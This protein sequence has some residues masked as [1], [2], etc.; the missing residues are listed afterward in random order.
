MNS[1]LKYQLCLLLLLSCFINGRSAPLLTNFTWNS[2]CL[3]DSISFRIT[4]DIDQIDSVK[5][6][7]GDPASLALDSSKRE[8]N[9]GHRYRATGPYTVTLIAFRGGV[10]DTTT[11]V[12]TIV[13]K[14]LVTMDP[15]ITLCENAPLYTITVTVDPST[16][17]TGMEVITWQDTVT[18]FGLTYDVTET[19]TYRI[20]FD[21]CQ[22]DDSVNVF[23]SPVP[24]FELG[25]DLNL[26]TDERITLDATAQ[27]ADY[28]WSTGE[29]SP[30]ILVDGN[31]SGQY[32]VEA[33]I[34]GCGVYRDT[35]NVNFSGMPQTFD[36]GKDTLLCAGE[37]ITIR[38]DV[39]AAI[40]Y[41][42]NTGARTQSINVSTR[43]A[44]WA[45]VTTSTPMGNCD[46]VDTINVNYNPLRDVNLG[47]DTTVCVGEALV[48]TANYG[49]GSYLWQDGS[50]Q[51]TFYVDSPGYYY[52]R[53]QIGRC[54]STDTIRVN[55]DDTLQVNLGPDTTI[56][57]LDRFV[58]SPNGAGTSFKW[59]DST[60]SP[61]F[62]VTQPGIYAV[63]ASNTCNRSVDSVEV[64][65]RQCDCTFYFPT[66]FSPNND[67]LNDL[68]RPV[69]RCFFT[70][71]K[72]WI[73]NRWGELQFFTTDPSV[74]WTGSIN[75]KEATTGTYVWI[76]EYKDSTTGKLYNQRGTVTLIR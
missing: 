74:A 32:W 12:I 3:N 72:L 37:T 28:L 71:Y 34:T 2:T 76:A 48:L 25:Q 8:E 43:N 60:S 20:Q 62:T 24:D 54:V 65:F 16:P 30:T 53:A 15:D 58:L 41:R 11:Q 70:D 18:G 9:A 44:Y 33:T 39:N 61:T 42:W 40:A 14:K 17:L 75:G 10:A 50:K 13:P 22:P 5:W 27:N 47:N 73:Y 19:G 23:Y 35:I 26:C 59:Q 29:T 68:F 21:G 66:G 69:Y 46:V 51:A 49:T 1:L 52:V 56:C 36:L 4:D 6:N 57:R 45:L 64:N 63:V 55:Y 67:G 38:A 31:R 7:F